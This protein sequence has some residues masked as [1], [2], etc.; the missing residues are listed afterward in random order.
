MFLIEDSHI[1]LIPYTHNDDA[2]MFFCWHDIDTQKG[3]N[4]TY[5]QALE[6]FRRFEIDCFPFWTTAVD[7]KLNRRVGSLRL[8]LNEPCPDLAIWIYPQYRHR[9]Y[10]TNSFALALK[11]I[12]SNYKYSEIAAGCFEDNLYSMRIIKKL[13]FIYY[14]DGDVVETDCFTGRDR[15]MQEFRITKSMIEGFA[16]Y[17]SVATSDLSGS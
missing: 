7:K 4:C 2:D 5:E 14:P 17:N 6:G 8:G 3:Y 13:G 11:Y 9:G 1:G 16:W 15:T 10:G 12:F